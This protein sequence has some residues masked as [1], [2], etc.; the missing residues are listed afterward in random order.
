MIKRMITFFAVICIFISLS[1]CG[2]NPSAALSKEDGTNEENTNEG[3]TGEGQENGSTEREEVPSWNDSH[4]SLGRRFDVAVLKEDAIYGAYI[5]ATGL[6]VVSLDTQ[7]GNILSEAEIA[8]ATDIWGITADSQK[9]MYLV[10]TLDEKDCFW[11]IDNNG[12]VVVR[13]DFELENSAYYE[14]Y[15]HPQPKG[16]YVDEK[17]TFYLWYELD[18]PA[19]EFDKEAEPD[20]YTVADRIYVKDSQLKTLFYE[21]IPDSN[22]SKLLGFS[23]D[24]EGTPT[25]L[26]QDTEG[27]YMRELAENEE[28][29]SRIPIDGIQPYTEF[30]KIAMTEGGFLF[31]QGNR[32]YQYLLGEQSYEQIL[33]LASYGIFATNIIYLGTEDD[34]SIRIVDNYAMEEASEYTVLQQ[35]ESDKLRLTLG[36]ITMQESSDLENAVT[37]FN[38]FQ[39][40]IRIEFINY[41]TAGNHFD[42]EVERLKLDIVRGNVPD[43]L[44]V[45]MIDWEMLANKGLWADLYD[46]M[47]LDEECRRD[48]LMPNVAEAYELGGHLYCIA[49]SFRIH[50]M[51][52]SESVV[53]GRYGVTFPELI[54]ILRDNEKDVNAIYGLSTDEFVLRDLCTMG[55][56][57]FIDWENGTCHFEGE[58]FKEVL[59]FAKEYGEDNTEGTLLDRIRE[60]KILMSAGMLYS[61][62]DYQLEKELY[63]EEVN[64]IG[65]PV[66]SGTGTAVS[67]RGSPL[68]IYANGENTDA[69]W[70]FVKYFLLNGY[71]G[72]GFPVIREQFDAKM[73]QDMEPSKDNL[74]RRTYSDRYNGYIMVYEAAQ[75]DVDA[76]RGLIE[77]ADCKYQFHPE[78]QNIISEEAEAY[79]TGQKSLEEVAALIQNRV[80]LYLEEHM[81]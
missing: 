21:Q 18:V 35:G 47:E 1:A 3:S 74:P 50:T 53:Q 19:T 36:T 32:L 17:G 39:D 8:G 59:E 49:P 7:S 5:N 11:K 22:G 71:D 54:Q 23:F 60:G 6:T 40:D 25:I 13:D 28:N 15:L 61:V 55:M 26:A 31:C 79:L 68:A 37:R 10:G 43:I 24:R 38:R 51:W 67:F 75:E 78:I 46:F 58:A 45:S 33:D 66:Q 41:Y 52:G 81:N 9:N 64:F 16:M 20:V 48:M 42:D 76:V 73:L 62:A 63:G 12:Q 44:E 2:R 4:T 30:E 80:N 69:A 57:E 77:R 70:Q 34:G 14:Y 72:N 56:D 27:V 65:Y 29:V